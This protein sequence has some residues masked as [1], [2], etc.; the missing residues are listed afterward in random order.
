MGEIFDALTDPIDALTA[1]VKNNRGEFNRFA[2]DV[3]GWI[4]M[5]V[6][7]IGAL[8]RFGRAMDEAFSHIPVLGARLRRR[9]QEESRFALRNDQADIDMLLG[10][11]PQGAAKPK[12]KT[13]EELAA[14][15]AAAAEKRQKAA[16]KAA[17]A[18]QDE[19]EALS[20][21]FKLNLLTAKQI[22]RAFEL[23]TRPDR[24]RQGRDAVAAGSRYRSRAAR[25]DSQD[26]SRTIHYTAYRSGPIFRHEAHS[27]R[28]CHC[29]RR[30]QHLV[31]HGRD[32]GRGAAQ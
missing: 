6:G 4:R 9:L 15:A 11:T 19:V 1:S 13:T 3:A 23:E 2:G 10:N 25:E 16:E 17:K 14:E 8:H 12:P 7:W 21:G 30:A 5:V 18:L 32:A 28:R 24:R 31:H 20:D 22:E 29:G 27:G 26:H